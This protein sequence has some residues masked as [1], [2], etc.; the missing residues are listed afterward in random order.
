MSDLVVFVALSLYGYNVSPLKRAQDLVD[1][2]EKRGLPCSELE[3]L[4]EIFL[5][6]HHNQFL[7][8]TLAAPTAEIYVEQA[9]ERYGK[10]AEERVQANMRYWPPF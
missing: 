8:T 6:P 7:G 2:F 1:H 10:E 4:L 9:M 3:V 5:D